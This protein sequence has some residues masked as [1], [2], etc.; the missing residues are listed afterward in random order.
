MK[1]AAACSD[2]RRAVSI[3][4]A[5]PAEHAHAIAITATDETKAVVLDLVDRW[6]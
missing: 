6:L 4:I 2:P 5:T 3:I 1:A